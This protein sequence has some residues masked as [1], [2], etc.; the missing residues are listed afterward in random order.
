MPGAPRS[1]FRAGDAGI[2][3]M[4]LTT[5]R[6]PTAIC[7]V[8]AA[9]IS[10]SCPIAYRAGHCAAS[11]A[12]GPASGDLLFPSLGDRPR[13]S[14][15]HPGFRPEAFSP[16]P[17]S[18]RAWSGSC[19]AAE[20]L[21]LGPDR[22]AFS[23]GAKRG[24]RNRRGTD[25]AIRQLRREPIRRVGPFRRSLPGRHVLPSRRLEARHRRA[26]SAIP[27]SSFRRADGAICGVL[28][29][30]HLKASAVRQCR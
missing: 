4:P 6:W 18:R 21:R 27:T 20:R 13:T 30:V 24:R 12:R 25:V 29:L 26:A 23:W 7:P 16:L 17:Q 11:I 3:E 14:R 10:G 5:L 28:P 8:A 19:G 1:P 22:P 9:V 2:V 15:G